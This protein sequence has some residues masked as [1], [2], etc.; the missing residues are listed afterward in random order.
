MDRLTNPIAGVRLY[1]DNTITPYH[2]LGVSFHCH[3]GTSFLKLYQGLKDKS[4]SLK[5]G[6]SL[7][8]LF[9]DGSRLPL[10]VE[11]DHFELDGEVLLLF[12]CQRLE[13]VKH[14][15]HIKNTYTIY[16][17][18]HGLADSKH[19]G[20]FMPYKTKAEGQDML[21]EM[22]VEFAKALHATV[23]APR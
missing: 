21:K 10:L 17:F 6:E 8:F 20:K 23:S 4:L 19:F 7:I 3:N 12:M 1:E 2:Y 13:K 18:D 16:H 11:N 22:A 5:I 14:T 15:N 9:G